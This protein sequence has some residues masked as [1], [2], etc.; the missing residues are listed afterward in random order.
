MIAMMIVGRIISIVDTRLIIGFGLSLTALSLWQMTGFSLQMDMWPIISTGLI[1]GFGLGFVFVP[2]STI[3]FAT[4]PP[5]RRTEGSSIFSLLRNVGSSIGISVV[6]ALLTENTQI[7]HS[8]LVEHVS[9]DN[10]VL[11]QP[12]MSQ[13][14]N[15]A[16]PA[17]LAGLDGAI[18]RQAAMLAY[19][20]DFWLMMLVCLATLPLLLL[21]RGPKQKGGP[22]VAAME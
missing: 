16:N 2:L 1:Q 4:L 11:H 6:E 13:L 8:S 15:L 22:A 21:L 17:G 12:G 19:L 20:N 5:Q 3:T 18:T 7:L 10:P 14:Y 9:P